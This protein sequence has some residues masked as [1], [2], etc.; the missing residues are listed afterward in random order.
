MLSDDVL[1]SELRKDWERWEQKL[2]G[3]EDMHISRC[4][5]PLKVFVANQVQKIQEHSDGKSQWKYVK[6]RDNPV[7]DALRGLDPRK[8]TSSSRWFSGPAFL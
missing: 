3:V 4:I 5:K 7:D 8:E 1:G 2:K 6:G